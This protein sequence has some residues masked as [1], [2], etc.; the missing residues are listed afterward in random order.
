MSAGAAAWLREREP[1]P[2]PEL[3]E[4]M[5]AALETP[6]SAGDAA[7]DE[8]LEEALAAAALRELKAALALGNARAAATP[9]LSADA[10]LTC[11][12]QA[13][14]E[15]G[16]TEAVRRLAEAY[17]LERFQGLLEDPA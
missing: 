8:A 13:A 6:E 17:G 14:A 3:L 16:G 7:V 12:F 4:R 10:L 15:R 5:T 1:A 11:A 9:L 2:P